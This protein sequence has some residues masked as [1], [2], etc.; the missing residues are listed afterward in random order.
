LSLDIPA[1][2]ALTTLKAFSAQSG[3][4]LLYSAEQVE[5]ARTAAVRGDYVPVDA[6]NRMLANTQLQATRDAR[7]GAL[8]VVRV[9]ADEKNGASRLATGQ[10][11]KVEDGTLKMDE[12]EVTGS[13]I[14]GLLGEAD[15][16]PMLV[17]S[18]QEIDR[19][20]VT[21]IGELSRLIPQAYSQGSYD[22]I[23]FGGQQQGTTTTSDGSIAQSTSVRSTFNL[24]GLGT[25]NT[26]VLI[27]GRRVAKTGII[28][29]NDGVNLAGIPVSAIERVEV[30]TDGASSIYGSDA[31]AGVINFILRKHYSGTEI[32]LTYENTFSSD[33]AVRTATITHAINKDKLSVLL[34]AT[35]QDRNAFAAVDRTFS[36]SDDWSRLGGT[37]SFASTA[38][39][40]GA[41][42][43]AT[44]P[45][46]V[47][48][49][50]GN[51]PGRTTP[52]AV[53][54]A[55]ATGNSPASAY[56]TVVGTGTLGVPEYTGDRAKYV[57]LI[58]PQRNRNAS[59][60]A[61]Y[62]LTPD[63]LVFFDARYSTALTHIEGMPVN[64]RNSMVVPADYPGNPFGVA[65][66]LNKT[67]WELPPIQGRKDSKS[68]NA[69]FSTGIRGLFLNDWRY[70]VSV[71]WNRG[72]LYDKNAY[73]PVLQ[74]DV[75]NAAIA[76]RSLV[77]F[78][79]SQTS[80]PND[81]NLL[82][83]MLRPGDR[84]DEDIHLSY[85]ASVDGPILNLP[86]GK[87]SIA[88]GAEVRD[89]KAQ[90]RQAIP[91]NP[92]INLSLLGDFERT[93]TSGYVETRIPVIAP[94]Q[95]IP[96]VNRFDLK[97]ALRYD[98]YSD[99][100][101]DYSPGYGAQWRPVS[102]VLLR[103]S[104]NDAFRAPNLQSSYRPVTNSTLTF[105]GTG[106][107]VVDPARG[108]EQLTGTKTS[109]IG[110]NL[111]LVPEHSTSFNY[112]VVIQPPYAL[113]KGFSFGVDWVEFDYKDRIA[114]LS[115]QQIIDLFPERL[116]RGPKLPTDPANWLGPITAIDTRAFNI[117]ELHIRSIDYQVNYS[118]NTPWGSV[119]LR[120][121]LTD[122]HEWE[123][124]G[125]PGAPAV[126]TLHSFP[127]RLTWQTYWTKGPW[128]AGV[129]GFYQEKQYATAAQT[130]V[131]WHSAIEWNVQ[132]A[133][134]F[135]YGSRFASDSGWGRFLDNTKL[136]VTVF[137]VLDREPPHIQG[138]AGFAVT[139]P[140]MARYAISLR[141]SF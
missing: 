31:V 61:E 96:L 116:T 3:G 68:S 58:A 94:Q 70:D 140:R 97:A 62:Q 49:S 117:A 73:D 6:L 26:L 72:I 63:T 59:M 105:S 71:D 112:G 109:I 118:R 34:S 138:L 17:I 132:A 56:V 52:Y 135:G 46:I 37:T 101:G 80:A 104:I 19:A 10:T 90:T 74:T 18:R 79:D 108:N 38:N 110:G 131:R 86:A 93:I 88:V 51:L 98:E 95:Q 121:A 120:G 50:S 126:S 15:I 25:Q 123:T 115:T 99:F 76:A 43:F 41:G 129:N 5:G 47:Q 32:D 40:F 65:V 42:G 106:T 91:E 9:T 134:D 114:S 44:G 64:F 29:G 28:R 33:T 83:S 16:T 35:Y 84:Y 92:L 57:N 24:R 85:S 111:G 55:G 100:G 13:R 133:Y 23:G 139:D 102:W 141:K 2:D 22:G 89:E 67:F 1:G 124:R 4:Q 45:G 130:T 27:N 136:S 77:L 81:R 119:D 82:L 7:S 128:G 21:S 54:P 103:A 78:Y 36:A 53:I 14:R 60:R 113:L 137:N 75:Y 11:A 39:S 107:P 8:S 20:G 122:Y 48:A 12:Y 66:R 30:L 127:T 87:L 125:L 69:N